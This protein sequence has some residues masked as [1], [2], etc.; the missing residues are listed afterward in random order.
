MQHEDFPVPG[1]EF[2]NEPATEQQKDLCCELARALGNPINRNGDWPDPF[3]K[4]DAAGMIA[5]LEQRLNHPDEPWFNLDSARIHALSLRNG[6]VPGQD[7][8]VRGLLLGAAKLVSHAKSELIALAATS[9]EWA[10][11][12]NPIID[13]L[14]SGEVPK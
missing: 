8:L 10:D 13:V 3:T 14:S 1:F 11:K 6:W 2:M 4:Y 12:L 5:S 7:K 9:Q